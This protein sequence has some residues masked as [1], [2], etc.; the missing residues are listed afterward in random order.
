[1]K[2]PPQKGGFFFALPYPNSFP[3]ERNVFL[4]SCSD[5]PAF[6]QTINQYPIIKLPGDLQEK[7][8]CEA[9]NWQAKGRMPRRCLVYASHMSRILKEAKHPRGI[10]ETTTGHPPKNISVTGIYKSICV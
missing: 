10:P 1:M 2:I 6:T 7:G 8:T 5:Y 4:V 3:E 9:G